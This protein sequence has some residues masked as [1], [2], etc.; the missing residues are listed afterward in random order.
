MKSHSDTR[1]LTAIT[2]LGQIIQKYDISFHCYA[3]DTQLYLPLNPNDQSKITNIF[4]CINEIKSWMTENFLQLNKDKSEIILFGP[5]DNINLLS[6]GLGN[7]STL[8]KP[9][10]KNLGV[11]FDS[12][13]KFDKQVNSVVKTSFFQLR[14]I[15]KIKSFLT[16][17][18]LE[19]VIHAF[20]TTRL[21]YCNSL[22]TGINQYSLSCLQLIQ[23]AAA[24]LL[25]GSQ[26][27][28]HITPV[29]A[30]LHWLPIKFQIDFK[31]LLFVYK[32]LNGAAPSYL[33]ELLISYS[34]SR[35]LRSADQG[36]LT[37]PHSCHKLRGDRAFSVAAPRLWNNIPP[38]VRLAP[39]S[40]SF[41]SR[42]KAY[43]F[44]LAFK[45][46]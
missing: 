19:K 14:I 15:S 21:D 6:S 35:P 33:S 16:F 4:N 20:I 31:L 2:P 32:A 38:S 17:S 10:V 26:K 13:L 45:S 7:L 43:F 40:D 24:R 42:L 1:R 39:S 8:I 9:H 25:T 5:P 41:K 29:L 23:N 30:S 22:Y 44:T 34:P 46:S 36:F 37:V 27:R 28:D 11:T 12:E 18:D 3:D